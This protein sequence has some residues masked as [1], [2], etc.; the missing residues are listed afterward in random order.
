MDQKRELS[1]VALETIDLYLT[2]EVKAREQAE[3]ILRLFRAHCKTQTN[4]AK[5]LGLLQQTFTYR[6]NHAK[7][8]HLED[9]LLMLQILELEKT[10]KVDL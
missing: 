5:K 3:K 8:I 7:K 4:A 10:E 9:A 6:F 2:N 1:P